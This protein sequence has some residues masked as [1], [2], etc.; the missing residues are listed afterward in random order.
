MQTLFIVE[1]QA[2]NDGTRTTTAPLG[3]QVTD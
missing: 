3:Y 2:M 1:Y